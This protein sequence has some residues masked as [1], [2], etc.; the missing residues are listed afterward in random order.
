MER[1]SVTVFNAEDGKK[2]IPGISYERATMWAKIANTKYAQFLAKGGHQ[3]DC[4]RRAQ[5][6]ATEE[7]RRRYESDKS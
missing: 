5:K 6:L 4:L 7:I 1:V 3:Q 2:A